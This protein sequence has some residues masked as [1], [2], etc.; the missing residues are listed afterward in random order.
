[1]GMESNEKLKK[2]K[3]TPHPPRKA[4]TGLCAGNGAASAATLASLFEVANVLPAIG[5][6]RSEAAESNLEDMW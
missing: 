5:L 2:K 1:M 3:K 4:P 6:V